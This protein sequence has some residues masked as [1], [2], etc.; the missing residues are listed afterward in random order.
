[1][2]RIKTRE[3]VK[4]IKVIDKARYGAGALTSA[5]AL[6][7]DFLDGPTDGGRLTDPKEEELS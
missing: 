6:G 5:A 2:S 4:D 3:G 1:M 7:A